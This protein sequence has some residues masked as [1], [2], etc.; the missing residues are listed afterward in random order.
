MGGQGCKG[1]MGVTTQMSKQA[2]QGGEGKAG[3]W[4]GHLRCIT[5]EVGRVVVGDGEQGQERGG[6]KAT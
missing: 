2:M 5:H 6:S 3:S 4:C 1:V